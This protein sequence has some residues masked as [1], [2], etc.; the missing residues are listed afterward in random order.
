MIPEKEIR[1]FYKLFIDENNKLNLIYHINVKNPQGIEEEQEG[2][3]IL[4][5]M[6]LA[7]FK[8]LMSEHPTEKYNLFVDTTGIKTPG[9]VEINAAK[10]YKEL[11]TDKQVKKVA[12][13]MSGHEATKVL[14]NFITQFTGKKDFKLFDNKDEAISWL[15]I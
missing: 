14:L 7:D 8:N 6:V 5:K 11:L 9:V 2:N 13:V 15:K 3:Y 1:N 10:V 4:A 12:V